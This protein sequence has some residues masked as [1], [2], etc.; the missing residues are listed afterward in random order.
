MISKNG[1]GKVSQWPEK[2][3]YIGEFEAMICLQNT[4]HMECQV[5]QNMILFAFFLKLLTFLC[6]LCQAA[7]LVNPEPRSNFA[8]LL[9]QSKESKYKDSGHVPLGHAVS[10]N[11]HW[12]EATTREGFAFGKTAKGP[13][14]PSFYPLLFIFC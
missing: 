13:S 14:L 11:Y 9:E 10:R 1:F 4:I 7:S 6:F 8:Q 2:R 3:F 12:P 5:E